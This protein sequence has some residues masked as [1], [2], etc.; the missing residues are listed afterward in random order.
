VRCAAV[1]VHYPEASGA[2]AALVVAG[3]VA[4]A[5]IAE[6]RTVHVAEVAPYRPGRFYDGRAT[7][8]AGRAATGG[9]ARAGR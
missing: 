2:W 9:S 5:A 3:D 6:E 4:F 1:D 8:D 7:P